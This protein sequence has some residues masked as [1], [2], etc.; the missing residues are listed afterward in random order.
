MMRK[1]RSIKDLDLILVEF[2]KG[3]MIRGIDYFQLK[4]YNNVDGRNLKHHQYIKGV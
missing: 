2:S 4:S 3:N 1:I